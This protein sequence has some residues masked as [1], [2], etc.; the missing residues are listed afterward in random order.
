MSKQHYSWDTFH[1]YV[2]E[3]QKQVQQKPDI[4]VSIGKGGSIPGVILAEHFKIN[5]LNLG[6]KSYNKQDRGSIHE[7]QSLPLNDSLRDM[8][9]L[10]VDDIADSGETFMYSV[11]KLK[12][13]FCDNIQTA[14]V[15]YKPCSKYK[16]DCVGITV[17]SNIWI[18]QPWEQ[19]E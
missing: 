11:N 9:I 6:L 2:H 19:I 1:S 17:D 3:I 8:K 12:G 15:F 7:Y 14:S 13:Y 10:L 16:P 4:I 5:N 18:V